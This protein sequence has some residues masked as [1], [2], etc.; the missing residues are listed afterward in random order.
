MSRVL[1]ADLALLVITAFWGV[2]F[3]VVKGALGECSPLAFNALR[4]TLATVVLALLFR[5]HWARLSRRVWMAGAVVGTLMAAGFGFQTIG[6]QFTTPAKSAFLT[7]LS[8]VLVPFYLA[9]GRRRAPGWSVAA[10]ASLALIGLYLIAI[11]PGAPLWAGGLNRGDLLTLACAG[12]FAGHIVGLGAYARRY[13]FEGLAILQVGFAAVWSWLAAAGGERIVIHAG[14]GLALAVAFTGLFATA[15]A[16]TTQAW[17]QQF[18]PATHTAILFAAEP[19]FAWAA[20]LSLGLER[21]S[22]RQGWGAALILAAILCI[23]L[24]PRWMAPGR[25]DRGGETAPSSSA[26]DRGL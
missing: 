10:G 5:R 23:E 17:A 6:L 13:P 8:V 9:L 20:S 21:L 7:G 22:P 2:S 26:Q 18:T 3:V 15:L 24:L 19:V 16:F 25:P 4:L 1:K 14:W 12:A 11:T